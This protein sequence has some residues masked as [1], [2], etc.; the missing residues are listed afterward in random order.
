MDWRVSHLNMYSEVE[1]VLIQRI[2]NSCQCCLN[3]VHRTELWQEHL[4][5]E[6]AG[7]FFPTLPE[8]FSINCPAELY[9][10][11]PD[12]KLTRPVGQDDF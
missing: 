11:W 1:I 2:Y 4:L 6:Q 9:R 8:S 10:T 7:Q 12:A 5:R 3:A